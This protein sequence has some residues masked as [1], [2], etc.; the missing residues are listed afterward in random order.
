MFFS[1]ANS[2]PVLVLLGPVVLP[3]GGHQGL[4]AHLL[5]D[6]LLNQP[7]P[8]AVATSVIKFN[9]L[10]LFSSLYLIVKTG[11]SVLILTTLV[12]TC[13]KKNY[14]CRLVIIV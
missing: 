6:D 12:A 7:V 10:M 13:D 8:L 2:V 14:F 9:F 11:M 3:I 4:Q 5:R 1:D